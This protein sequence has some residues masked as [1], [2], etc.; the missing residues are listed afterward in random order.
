MRKLIAALG[1][2]AIA[3]IVFVV[4][5]SA[6]TDGTPDGNLHP[7]VGL[8][9]M[10]VRG[11][12]AF[13]CSGTLI[14]PTFVLTAGHCAGEPGE[15]SGMR[16]FAESDVQ[17]DPT[18]PLSGGP[19]TVD[20]VRWASFPGFTEDLFFLHDVGVLELA[21]PINLPSSAYGRLPTAGQLD[22]L[23][24]RRGLQDVTFTSVGYGLQQINPVHV[25]SQR[26]RMYAQPRLIQINV[27]GFTGDFS[28]L[29]SNNH[30]TGGACFGDSGGPNYLGGTSSNLIAGVTSF[31]I[32]GNCAGTGGVFRLDKQ[33]VIDFVND[34]MAD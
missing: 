13:R 32:N 12:P 18:Y 28:L 16:F 17:H 34:F 4:P 29:L 7:A 30:S 26:I 33:P 10:D 20:A 9:V 15:F 8:I 27:P 25:V 6:I 1:A 14:A 23:K 22:A 5:A 24:T 19:N 2:L 11:A 31:G 3:L 21:H